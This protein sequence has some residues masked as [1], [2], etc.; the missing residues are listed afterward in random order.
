LRNTGKIPFDFEINLSPIVRKQIIRIR[1]LIGQLQG[2]TRQRFN[3][4]IIPSELLLYPLLSMP[5]PK[6]FF[7]IYK[8]DIIEI[9]YIEISIV[10][11]SSINKLIHCNII[12]Y[13][14]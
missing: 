14:V 11:F 6:I 9:L 4:R 5:Q 3:C 10:V 8:I 7:Q 13:V 1:P 12:H 2:S